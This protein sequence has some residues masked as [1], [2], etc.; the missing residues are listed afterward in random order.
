MVFFL[1]IPARFSLKNAIA[2]SYTDFQKGRDLLLRI[3]A[4]LLKWH[5]NLV[6]I[7][8]RARLHSLFT[9]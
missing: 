5:K 8:A 2:F 3:V 1:S 4:M 9:V 7:R 6:A